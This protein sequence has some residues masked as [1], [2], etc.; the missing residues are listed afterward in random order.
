MNRKIKVIL[1][2]ATVKS[3]LLYNS[4]TCTINK[5]MQKRIDC[6]YSRMLRMATNT[7]WKEKTTNEVLFQDLH[8]LSQIIREIRMRLS[9]HC[10]RH[11]TK[12]TYNLLLRVPTRGKRNRVRQPM[13]YI[14]GLILVSPTQTK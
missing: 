12:M 2:R 9:G 5:N 13:T 10:I 4:R 1:F 8:P 3:A 14:D 6:C 11:S 7:S